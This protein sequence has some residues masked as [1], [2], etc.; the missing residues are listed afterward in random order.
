MPLRSARHTEFMH[1]E[2]PGIRIPNWLR[3]AI[4]EAK[5]DA[6]ALEIGMEACEKLAAYIR[7]VGAA[8][9]YI[10]PPANSHEMAIRV[11]EAAR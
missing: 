1:N 6:S 5:D 11:M 3:T 7:K 8:G 10:M 9:L 2:V 4:G